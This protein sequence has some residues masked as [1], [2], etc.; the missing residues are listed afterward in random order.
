MTYQQNKSVFTEAA[1]LGLFASDSEQ[2]SVAEPTTPERP[3]VQVTTPS[4]PR[5]VRR[6]TKT[7]TKPKTLSLDQFNELAKAE[8]AKSFAAAAA[9][10]PSK[11]SKSGRYSKQKKVKRVVRKVA[12]KGDKL[13]VKVEPVSPF[14]QQKGDFPE[15]LG[16]APVAPASLGQWSKSSTAV[17]DSDFVDPAVIARAEQNRK[18]AERRRRDI[19][20]QSLEE[21]NVEYEMYELVDDQLMDES[22]EVVVL[23]KGAAAVVVQSQDKEAQWDEYQAYLDTEEREEAATAADEWWSEDDC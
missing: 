17:L 16:A 4:A 21:F 2:E 10:K 1:L 3:S 11:P 23:R 7:K 20:L 18:T 5:K 14:E 13:T 22:E 9:K 15:S 8:A 19:E 12:K 6:K